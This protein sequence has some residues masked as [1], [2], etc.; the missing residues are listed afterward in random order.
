M[1]YI[2]ELEVGR[3][4]TI[5]SF[6]SVRLCENFALENYKSWDVLEF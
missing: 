6:L 1:V 5:Q 3:A 2:H 4:V